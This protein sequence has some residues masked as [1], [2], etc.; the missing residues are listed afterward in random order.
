VVSKKKK[1]SGKRG[2]KR[3]IDASKGKCLKGGKKKRAHLIRANCQTNFSLH[4]RADR[5]RGNRTSSQL[6]TARKV[7]R[8]PWP[9]WKRK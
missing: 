1:G 5:R 4:R 6:K 3:E 2:M 8:S 9:G 7:S